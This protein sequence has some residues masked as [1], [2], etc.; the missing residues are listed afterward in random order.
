MLF[1]LLG[2][3]NVI[4]IHYIFIEICK[5]QTYNAMNLLM[6]GQ[7]TERLIFRAEM[8]EICLQ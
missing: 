1:M 8:Q 4:Q 5:S 2:L 6:K 7:Q 3:I